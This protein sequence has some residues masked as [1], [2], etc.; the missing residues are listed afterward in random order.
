MKRTALILWFLL[1]LITVSYGQHRPSDLYAVKIKKVRDNVYVAYRPEPLRYFVEGNV[2][3]II[4]ERDVVVVDAGGAPLA[5]QQV[6]TEIKKLTS[7]PVRYLI[8][9]HPHVDHTLGNQEYVKAFPGVEIISHPVARAELDSDGRTYVAETIKNFATRNE[10]SAELF[11]RLREEGKP[12][13]D[14]VINYWE[15]YANEDIYARTE[16]Y[17]KASIT[18]PTA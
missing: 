8:N 1:A 6:I 11:K 3:T 5:A 9:T 10:R 18:L 15:R 17:R 12:G 13:T 16:E 2:T 7:N 4:N 14:Q